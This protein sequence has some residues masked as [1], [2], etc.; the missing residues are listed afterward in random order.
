MHRADPLT[1]AFV[2]GDEISHKKQH[3]YK[4]KNLISRGR[5]RKMGNAARVWKTVNA[6][7]ETT[8]QKS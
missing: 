8:F 5:G 4:R 3:N 2:L 7:G 6:T 1:A